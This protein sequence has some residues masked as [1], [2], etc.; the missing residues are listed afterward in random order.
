[1]VPFIVEV[2][3][4]GTYL[5]VSGSIDSYIASTSGHETVDSSFGIEGRWGWGYVLG[6]SVTVKINEKIGIQAGALYYTGGSALD[7]SGTYRADGLA[8]ENGVPNYLQGSS[9]DFTGLEIIL[10]VTYDM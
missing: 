10:G 3:T 7:L 2:F 8:T 5:G 1:M 9:L 6:G 4:I